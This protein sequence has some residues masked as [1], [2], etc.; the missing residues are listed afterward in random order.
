VAGLNIKKLDL[1]PFNEL[2]SGKYRTLGIDWIYKEVKAQ[3]ETKLLHLKEIVESFGLV[4][5]IGGLW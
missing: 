1:L 3:D 5:T 4:V 2:P